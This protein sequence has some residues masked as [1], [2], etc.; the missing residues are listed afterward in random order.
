MEQLIERLEMILADEYSSSQ[1]KIWLNIKGGSDANIVD[2]AIDEL[3]NG[4][5]TINEIAEQLSCFVVNK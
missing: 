2:V 4:T 5:S 3:E 1:L